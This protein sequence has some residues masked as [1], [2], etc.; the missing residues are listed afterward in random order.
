[1]ERWGEDIIHHGI[2]SYILNN[3]KIYT[4]NLGDKN[5]Y[6]NSLRSVFSDKDWFPVSF[7]PIT[8]FKTT[9][10]CDMVVSNENHASYV[11]RKKRFHVLLIVYCLR[12][13]Y[14]DWKMLEGNILLFQSQ[15]VSQR[16]LNVTTYLRCVLEHRCHC[17]RPP[18]C[19]LLGVI[20]PLL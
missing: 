20:L 17:E 10:T 3:M 11:A 7:S 18:F 6:T 8:G 9:K 19:W 4:D 1:M 12:N 5:Q 2:K 15:L 16:Q 14:D 13:A